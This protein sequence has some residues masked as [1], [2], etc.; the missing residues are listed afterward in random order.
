MNDPS[1][2]IPFTAIL[3]YFLVAHTEDKT[4]AIYVVDA[5]AARLV[6]VFAQTGNEDVE[7]ATQEIVVLAPELDEDVFT[8]QD[9]VLVPE[10]I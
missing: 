6:Q 4:H 8:S 5:D 3:I 7:A 10:E 2:L 9:L 1:P